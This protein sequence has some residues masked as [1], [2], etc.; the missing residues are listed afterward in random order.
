MLLKASLLS[1]Y[2]WILLFLSWGE[3]ML[4]L[5]QS[6]LLSQ[7]LLLCQLLLLCQSLLLSQLLLLCQLL[8][9]SQ[10][11]LLRQL[12]LNLPMD[13]RQ[14]VKGVHSHGMHQLGL[15]PAAPRRREVRGE[16]DR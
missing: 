11:L 10:L 12:L 15:L 6:L 9:L 5:N 7:S 3:L 8:L 16:V 2:W 13:L 4:L 1:K 14:L